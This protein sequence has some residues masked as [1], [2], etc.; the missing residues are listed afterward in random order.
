MKISI[1]IPCFDQAEFLP[2]TLDSILTQTRQPDEVILVNDG[3]TDSTLEIA[4]RYQADK[5]SFK[6]VIVNQVNKGLSSARNTGIMNA[7]S[8]YV[9]PLDSDDMLQDNAL[10]VLERVAKETK[11]DIT[12]PSMKCFGVENQ[13]VILMSNPSLKDF[14]TAN[15]IPY[16]ALIRKQALVECGG[17]SPRM[18]HGFEDWHL[19]FD[20][21]KRGNTI[22]TVPEPLFLYRT[23]P[24]SMISSANEHK[25]ELIAQINKDFF[26]A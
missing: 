18:V 2:D 17:Y 19:W 26:S 25:D 8:D 12:A 3:S 16:C 5:H 22:V 7:A 11:A 9:L 6:F 21:L 1:I 24:N 14:A 10:E 20:L 23:R 13:T 4:K 15:R